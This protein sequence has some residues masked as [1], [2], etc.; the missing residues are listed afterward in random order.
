MVATTPLSAVPHSSGTGIGALGW[1]STEF[2]LT[3]TARDM[4]IKA[5]SGKAIYIGSNGD[6][7]Y[8]FNSAG[9]FAAASDLGAD[10]GSANNRFR[11]IFTGGLSPS[12][13]AAKT[14]NFT[15]ISSNHTIP[16]DATSGAIVISLVSATAAVGI[17]QVIKKIDAS[18]NTVTIDPSG[19][20]T[21]DGA[22]TKVLSTQWESM[23]IQ[24][25]GTNWYVI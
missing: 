9:N 19:S 21:I 23:M 25:N 4:V 5:P 12:I 2:T 16:V 11:G 13:L 15:T 10:L 17:I 22:A 6:T 8:F 7:G 1:V 3:V 20:E 14:S 24:S 18:V